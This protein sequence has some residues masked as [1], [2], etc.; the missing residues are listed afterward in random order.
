[1]PNKL[2]D[3]RKQLKLT[4]EQMAAMFNMPL[5]TYQRYESDK[6]VPD[7]YAGKRLAKALDTTVEE[8][9]WE[10]RKLK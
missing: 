5:V 3:I 4:Q 10:E 9:F 6:R 1:M 8:L 7:V 2:K